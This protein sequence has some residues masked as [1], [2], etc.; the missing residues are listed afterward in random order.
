MRIAQKHPCYG[1]VII[2]V[3]DLSCPVPVSFFGSFFVALC[4]FF[5]A[6]FWS[7]L[8]RVLKWHVFEEKTHYKPKYKRYERVAQNTTVKEP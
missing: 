2:S 1:N 3:A 8:W 4:V 5:C 6:V 7:F